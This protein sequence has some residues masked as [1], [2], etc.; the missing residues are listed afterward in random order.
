MTTT[1]NAQTTFTPS[2]QGAQVLHLSAR[3]S[4]PAAAPFA[5]NL[6][7]LQAMEQEARLILARAVLRCNGSEAIQESDVARVLSLAGLSTEN[8]TLDHVELLLSGHVQKTRLREEASARAG[9]ALTLPRFCENYCLEG[10]ECSVVLLLFMLTTSRGFC[11]MFYLCGFEKERKWTEGMKI[12]SLLAIICRDYREQIDRRSGFSVDASLIRQEIVLFRNTLDETSNILDETVCLHER[13]VRFILDDNNLYST[14]FRFVGRERSCVS[15]DQV[16]MDEAAKHE[17]V[18]HVGNYLKRREL[19]QRSIL[20]EFYGYGTSLTLLFHG[21]PGTGKTMLA[22][23]LACHF[24]R[25]LF[26]LRLEDLNDTPG[27]YE[28]NF[29][30]LFREASLHGGIVFFDESDDIFRDD[31][32]ASRALLIEIE[33]AR[34][35][36]ILATNKPVELDPAM[37]RR[38]SMKVSFAIPDPDLRLCMWQS[39]I[40]PGVRLADDIDLRMLSERYEFTGGLI[41]NT[42]FLA[43]NKAM[44]DYGIENTVITRELLSHA[45]SLQISPLAEMSRLCR[46]YPPAM[47]L[48]DIPLREY[49]KEQIRHLA[50]AYRRLK[51]GGLGL[52][53]LLGSCDIQ[54]GINAVR[55]LAN[56]CGLMVREF[57]FDKALSMADENRVIDPVSQKKVSPMRYA[58]S[59]G[60]GS[61]SV[62]LFV[63]HNREV[64]RL[65]AD[66]PDTARNMMLAELT[67]HL[68]THPGLFCLVTR[69]PGKVRLPA[70]FSLR[71]DLEYPPEEEQ[72][73][74]WEEHIGRSSV[75]DDLVTLVERHPMHITEIDFLARQTMIHAIIHDGSGK[76]TVADIYETI[77][78]HQGKKHQPVLFGENRQP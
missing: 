40:P 75:D 33:K 64:E 52:S 66:T 4:A 76:P 18:T 51:E 32:R 59:P 25:Q 47:T 9:I 55:A 45:A 50:T 19:G 69:P 71:F 2:D 39:L 62:I 14:M 26:T 10:F 3:D 5:D 74:R 48:E 38:I 24:D 31:S 65:L 72:I 27:S 73:R 49:Q 7:H 63:D 60:T 78:R 57:D 46:T 6:D 42:I 34:C 29:G 36:V 8:A 17:V 22:K 37:E 70:E 1:M 30:S 61:A 43:L 20:D 68:R 44:S 67:S 12:G 28:E 58:F 35:V 23:A 21:P 16:V 54:T 53:V 13:F 15:L 77:E 56:E 11:E 41:K